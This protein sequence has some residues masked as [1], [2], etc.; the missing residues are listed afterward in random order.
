MQ[1]VEAV[2]GVSCRIGEYVSLSSPT[3]PVQ[4]D[5]L[6][7]VAGASMVLADITGNS[8]NVHI[9]IGA[10][11]AAGVPIALLRKGP[12]RPPRLHAPG[13]AGVRLRHRR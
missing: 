8:P 7:A 10:A 5:I 13:P 9:E 6:S 2:T 1:T 12:P 4:R 11:L 3:G